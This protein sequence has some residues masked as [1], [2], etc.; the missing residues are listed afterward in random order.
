MMIDQNIKTDQPDQSNQP[1]QTNP[2][3]HISQNF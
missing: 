3:K 1:D 2:S